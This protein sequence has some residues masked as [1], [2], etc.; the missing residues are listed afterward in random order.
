MTYRIPA[1]PASRNVGKPSRHPR[2]HPTS[3]ERTDASL[4][5]VTGHARTRLQA[6]TKPKATGQLSARENFI[7]Q[8]WRGTHRSGTRVDFTCWSHE[9][10]L[11]PCRLP[12][13]LTTWPS[14]FSVNSSAGPG[15]HT[16][17]VDFI[18][19]LVSV[20]LTPKAEPS[21]FRVECRRLSTNESGE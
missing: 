16:F 4:N 15:V 12:L 8:T 19:R 17:G 9:C 14:H 18:A 3:A 10:N 11:V 6:V 7:S 21:P 20:E 2:G 13:C 1:N 5:A